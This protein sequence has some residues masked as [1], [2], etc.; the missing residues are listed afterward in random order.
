M[1]IQIEI[2][3]FFFSGRCDVVA[4]TILDVP[5]SATVAQTTKK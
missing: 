2:D 3:I 1:E 4:K 5:K